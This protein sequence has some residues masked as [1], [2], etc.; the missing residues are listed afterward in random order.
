MERL[1][2]FRKRKKAEWITAHTIYRTLS[3]IINSLRSGP[4]INLNNI[5]TEF[6]KI[7]YH[8]KSK[9]LQK[10]RRIIRQTNPTAKN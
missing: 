8:F 6:I 2:K 5:L 3:Q 10:E 1:Q 7:I 9:N 4:R